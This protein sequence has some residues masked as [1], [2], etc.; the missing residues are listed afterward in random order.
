LLLAAA[1][2][3]AA[4]C[5]G[6]E[7]SDPREGRVVD[8]GAESAALGDKELAAQIEGVCKQT[9]REIGLLGRRLAQ[10]LAENPGWDPLAGALVR[11]GV[12]ILKRESSR[13]N[14][15]QAPSAPAE[16]YVY[17]GLLDSIIELSEQRLEAGRADEPE[18]G[19]ALELL[20]AGL[21]DEQ[22]ASAQ[23]LGLDACSVS[24]TQALGGQR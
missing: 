22:V 1:C 15:L 4:G 6:T 5:G 20:I 17:V 23:R 19:K 18:R 7:T 3:A 11:P 12:R 8:S 14:D 24:F 2:L 16:L 21:A 9:N 13:L 10:N